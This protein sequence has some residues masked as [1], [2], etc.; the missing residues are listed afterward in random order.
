MNVS[1]GQLEAQRWRL[2]DEWFFARS[3]NYLVHELW[4]RWPTLL[5]ICAPQTQ[6][7]V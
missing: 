7:S 2:N 3:R 4:F 5:W 1:P 6:V